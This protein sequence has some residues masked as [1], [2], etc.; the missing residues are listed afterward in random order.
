VTRFF[1]KL[2]GD[3]W[4]GALMFVGAIKTG[5][6]MSGVFDVEM[7]GLFLARCINN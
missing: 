6:A 7:A 3:N 2:F 4:G 1:D 5:F